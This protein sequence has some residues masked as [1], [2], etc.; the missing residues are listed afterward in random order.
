MQKEANATGITDINV[1]KR[2][3]TL[4]RTL[5]YLKKHDDEEEE[6]DEEDDD[7]ES[8]KYGLVMTVKAIIS[9]YENGYQGWN[10]GLVTY[11][12]Y[13]KQLSELRTFIQQEFEEIATKKNGHRGFWVEGVSWFK[14]LSNIK[15]HICTLVLR[16]QL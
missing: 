14:S 8:G 12:S 16:P 15:S 5:D 11:W 10:D 9:A 3:C 1:L 7:E 4:R 6:E 2:L 13:G